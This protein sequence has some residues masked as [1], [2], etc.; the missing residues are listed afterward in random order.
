MGGVGGK[1]H[2]GH[3][4]GSLTVFLVQSK[5]RKA[6][7]FTLGTGPSRACL[8]PDAIGNTLY[9]QATQRG[10]SDALNLGATIRQP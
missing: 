6:K 7:A 3:G 5:A 8:G 10:A 1:D 2:G 9:S 4:D